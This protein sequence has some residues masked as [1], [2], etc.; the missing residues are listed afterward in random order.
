MLWLSSE[1]LERVLDPADY[2]LKCLYLP[3]THEDDVIL[4]KHRI[5]KVTQIKPPEMKN[6]IIQIK[7]PK[8]WIQ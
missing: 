3:K 4:L 5:L 6:I 7:N 1:W 8:G 2:S